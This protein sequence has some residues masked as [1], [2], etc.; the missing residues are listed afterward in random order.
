MKIIEEVLD[1]PAENH[2]FLKTCN[3]LQTGLLL[4]KF[5]DD[6]KMHFDYSEY[7]A[8]ALKSKCTEFMASVLELY[9][10]P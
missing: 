7:S 5:I 6:V 1:Y 3:P 10:C 8:Q 2:I 4:Y 9:K